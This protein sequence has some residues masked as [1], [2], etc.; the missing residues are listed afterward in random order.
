[1]D[2]RSIC[3][4]IDANFNRAREASRVVEEFC[5][6]AL[7]SEQLYERVKK[8]RHELSSAVGRLDSK[9][10]LACRDTIRDVG[11][12]KVMDE[13]L[14]RENLTDC[15]TAGCKRLTEAL[16]VL[17]E[18]VQTQDQTAAG[19][20]E[21]LRYAAY[22]LEKDI[23]LFNDAVEKYKRVRL[24]IVI[25]SDF[26][27][28][29]ISLTDKCVAGGADCIQMRSK[30]LEDDRL[31]ATASQFVQICKN[32]GVLG[33]INDR[34]DIAVAADADGVHL[35]QDDLPVDQVR[36]LQNTP[37]IIGKST[38][39]IEQLKAAID[40]MPAYVGLGP[41]HETSTKP[42]ARAVGLEYVGKATEILKDTG[43]GHAAI[44]GINIGNVDDAINAGARTIAVCSAVTHSPDP[45]S[46]CR[47][48]KQ[49]IEN[50]NDG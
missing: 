23:V 20:L 14:R 49:R 29:I 1:M 39:S 47:M 45:E 3:R 10:L 48:L 38:H 34:A 5:R 31:F 6:F 40:E 26:P 50:F 46:A 8:L 30:S 28:E 27:L 25:T 4:I 12:G 24:Y 42:G 44:G 13:Q 41:V 22:T 11:V 33:I 9:S 32:G 2:E 36:R 21:D 18:V 7:N 43:I 17:A 37:L 16:R 19:T 15:F 35:G